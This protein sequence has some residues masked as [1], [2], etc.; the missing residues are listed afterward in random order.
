MLAK[1]SNPVSYEFEG[2]LLVQCRECKWQF[3]ENVQV[4][5]LQKSGQT[6]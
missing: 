3:N 2:R 6:Q 4:T 5:T 1:V